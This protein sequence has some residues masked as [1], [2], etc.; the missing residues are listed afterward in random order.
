MG[1][2]VTIDAASRRAR[3]SG[4]D[5]RWMPLLVIAVTAVS[6]V[7]LTLFPSIRSAKALP[8]FAR[9][10]GLECAVCHVAFPELTP[11][12]RLFKLKGYTMQ[13]GDS[14][15][16]P[17]AAFLQPAFT[18]TEA[19]QAGGIPPNFGPNNNFALE[20]ASLF[21]GGAI[22][23]ELGIGA[24]AQATY[25]SASNRFGW[26]NTD[27][28]FA[29]TGSVG[30]RDFIF[31]LTLNNNPSVQ[32]VWNTTPAWRFPFASSTL[33]PTPAA[34]PAIEGA[35]A[36]RVAGLGG[37]FFWNNLIYAEFTAYSTLSTRTLTTLGA[38]S[39]G[40]NSIDGIAPYWRLA[41]EPSWDKHSLEIGTFGM[42]A[43]LFPQRF[44]GAGTDRVT[45]IGIDAQ[46]QFI[47][48]RDQISL[49]LSWTHED[50]HFD[51]SQPLGLTANLR[52]ELRS[53][54]GKASYFYDHTYGL[55]LAYFNTSGST[56]PVLF[57]PNPI[58][59]SASG[60]PDS[61]GWIIEADY[62]PFMHGGPSFWPW[63]NVRFA[64]QYVLY[65][66]FNGGRADYDGFG[67]N[68]SDN[69][70]LFLLAWTAF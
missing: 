9:Q 45:D 46:Y 58:T 35:F 63:L 19:G 65:D 18:H 38:D 13:G 52:D 47:G 61:S 43:N 36:Q 8:S 3:T 10:T 17:L 59:G 40:I 51:A 69:N 27:I 29:R 67:R 5:R 21:Y 44:T 30:D 70:T 54:H 25:D 50:G 56:D 15:L 48:D 2:E 28:R 16:P 37:Y 12:G 6:A 34:A 60:S 41:L 4:Q 68:A 31:G 42:S 57:A 7:F 39:T 53:V 26:D 49:Q 62:V 20:Q 11:T 66:K 23:T 64:V 33:A 1:Q 32:D 22:S 14:S 24:F 55:N